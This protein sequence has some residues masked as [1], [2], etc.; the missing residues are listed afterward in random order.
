MEYNSK[1]V[2]TPGSGFEIKIRLFSPMTPTQLEDVKI[3]VDGLYVEERE[4]S[5]VFLPEVPTKQ[6]WDHETY[7]KELMKKAEITSGEPNLQK[8]QTESVMIF[9]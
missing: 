1:L 4:K 9:S 2:R 3:G 8:F 6:R 5:A 7:L